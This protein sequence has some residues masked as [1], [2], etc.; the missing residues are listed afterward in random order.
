MH[1]DYLSEHEQGHLYLRGLE[2][3][4]YN[5]V[6][7]HLEIKFPDHMLKEPYKLQDIQDAAEFV[8]C[9]NATFAMQIHPQPAADNNQFATAIAQL[10]QTL[11][12]V[13]IQQQCPANANGKGSR[14]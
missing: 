9:S 5:H 7:H 11:N 4:L 3:Q 12:Q 2:D 14:Y 1:K 8:L 13:L 10:M 6:S